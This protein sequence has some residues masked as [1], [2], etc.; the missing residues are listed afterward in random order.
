LTFG[1][2]A[3]IVCPMSRKKKR[4]EI[5]EFVRTVLERLNGH[6]H[7]SYVV[8]GAVRDLLMGRPV[9]DW[10]VAS[11]ASPEEITELFQDTRHFRLKHQTV[12]LVHEDRCY[13]VTSFRGE[14]EAGTR[15]I[16]TDLGHRDFTIDAMALGAGAEEVLDPFQGREDIRK[17]LV[18]AVRNPGDRFGE[19]PLR[20]LRSVRLATELGFRIDP[21]TLRAV[22]RMGGEIHRVAQERIR[23]EL[24]KI[25]LS[26]RPSTG[27]HLMK[28]TGLLG[29]V[30][31][32]LLEGVGMRQ[33]PLVHR[34]TVFRHIMETLD[35][36]EAA[37]VLRLAALLHD[38]AKPRTREKIAG[39]FHFYGHEK[40]SALLA[41]EIME[42]LK[43]SNDT[44]SQVAHLIALHMRDLDY[45]STWSDGAVRR[46]IRDVGE[47]NVGGFLILREADLMAHGVVGR[48]KTA[49]FSEL[50]VRIER[51]LGNPVPRKACDLAIDG[52]N[53]MES[54]HLSPGPEVGRVLNLLMERVTD[55][56]S[57]N[58]EE[59]LAAILQEMKGDA[60]GKNARLPAV[61]RGERK[62]LPGKGGKERIEID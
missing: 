23:E 15:D 21:E 42:R 57:L 31:P 33:N 34:Y 54:L 26:P 30:L 61:G 46:L 14:G 29:E 24:M 18:R 49:L 45:H 47:E 17:R 3:F 19:D 52:H 13:E 62:R 55:D 60:S 27:F 51:L 1:A 37:P 44:T 12:T 41:R 53:V 6:G 36:V 48:K 32:E 35:R 5:P 20:M 11:S 25:L 50:K 10:D 43:F 38:I 59:C 8:G 2:G 58:T 16:E 22:S 7:D 56:P 40:A 39:K 28:K 9:T 4:T